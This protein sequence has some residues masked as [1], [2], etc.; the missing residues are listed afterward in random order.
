MF[1]DYPYY[2]SLEALIE[3]SHYIVYAE[4]LSKSCE[5]RSITVPDKSMS[6]EADAI[7]RPSDDKM[8]I[9]TYDVRV[10]SSANDM[11]KKD[12]ILHIMQTGGED[13][14]TIYIV[15]GTPEIRLN[16]K[17]LFFLSKSEL[18]EDGGWLMN[19]EQSLY[20]LE[21]NDAAAAERGELEQVFEYIKKLF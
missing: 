15:E 6:T 13:N 7:N 20:H 8:M 18:I 5:M 17:Y 3:N 11:A 12:Q 14:E 9:T 2:P 16:D 4:V 10:I 21:G 1:A 19:N